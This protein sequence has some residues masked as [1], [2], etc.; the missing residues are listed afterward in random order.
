M[1]FQPLTEMS[2]LETIY[3]HVPVSAVSETTGAAIDPTGDTVTMAF[4]NSATLPASPTWYAADWVTITN[5]DGTHTY[6]A[7]CLVGP[8]GGVT[9]LAPSPTVWA[10][11]KVVDNPQIPIP[12]ASRP[13]RVR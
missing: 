12:H 9:T 2:R 11:A 5:A 13:F 1:A 6:L 3:V 10:H 4:A 7:R 8:T